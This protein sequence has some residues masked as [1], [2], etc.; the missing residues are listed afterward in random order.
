MEG[1]TLEKF[2]NLSISKGIYL[3]DIVRINYTTIEAKVG[4]KEFK[5]LRSVMKKVN[6]KVNIKGKKGYPFFLHKLKLRKMLAFG[7]LIAIGLIFFLTSFIWSVEIEGNKN[8]SKNKIIEY[9]ESINIK[10]GISKHNID[11]SEVKKKL[12]TDMDKFIFAKVDI[13][14]T[15]LIIEVKEKSKQPTAFSEGEPCNIISDRKAVIEKVIA[16]KGKAVVEKGDIVREGEIL[17]TG[18]IENEKLENPLFVHAEGDIFA[19]TWYNEIVKEPIVKTIK[20]ETGEEYVTKEIKFGDKR[21]QLS[22]GEIPFDNY[23]EEIDSKKVVSWKDF[24]LPVE[25]IKHTYKEV[26][27]K[28]ITQNVNALKKRATV[29]GVN[30]IMNRLNKNSK[31]IGKDVTFSIENNILITNVKVEVIEKIGKKAKI[32]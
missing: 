10:S 11:T 6:C 1:L 27:V 23:I 4:I 32:Q 25:I 21:L 20:E 9:L 13:K 8:V 29:K 15:K 14:G 26:N 2:I 7:A 24:S 18:V 3:W 22:D 5:K 30:T 12:L 17:I 28:K 16:R 31:V 19:K